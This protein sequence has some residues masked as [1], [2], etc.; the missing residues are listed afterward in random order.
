MLKIPT[1]LHYITTHIHTLNLHMNA[2]THKHT[3]KNMYIYIPLGPTAMGIL[4]IA[5]QF[6]SREHTGASNKSLLCPCVCLIRLETQLS[7]SVMQQYNA[8]HTTIM[9]NHSHKI[10][11]LLFSYKC[12][13]CS[14]TYNTM[15]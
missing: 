5:S 12:V 8:K 3:R 2:C 14:T 10:L 6:G 1:I 11:S 7:P 13:S 9:H 4:L 15:K